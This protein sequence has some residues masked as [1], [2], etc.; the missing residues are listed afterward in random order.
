M[1]KEKQHVFSARTTE[2]GLKTLNGLK[3]RLGLS[4][5]DLLIGA[6][7]AHY[8]VDVPKPPKRERPKKAGEKGKKA[9]KRPKNRK[10]Q[11]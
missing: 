1:P 7:N 4:W 6:V 5:D 3:A 11:A 9:E 2:G 8:G 10:G